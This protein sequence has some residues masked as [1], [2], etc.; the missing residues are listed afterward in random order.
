MA[1]AEAL[2]PVEEATALARAEMSPWLVAVSA[3]SEPSASWLTPMAS[4][5][6]VADS[7]AVA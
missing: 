6:A 4:A 1:L 5:L 2:E 7:A 3:A